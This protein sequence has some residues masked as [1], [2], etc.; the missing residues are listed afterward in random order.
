MDRIHY[1]GD[2]VLTGSAI[3]QSLLEY[4]EALAKAGSSDTVDIPSRRSD[5]SLGRANL[6]IGPA[7]QL[8][9]ETEESDFDEVVDEAT[10]AYLG[11][12]IAML[13]D[14]RALPLEEDSNFATAMDELEIPA[15]ESQAMG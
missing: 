5:G 7:S 9:S 13:S 10:V 3:A 14:T 8:V 1:A 4:A 15:E 12:Q 11:R 2:S 6:L